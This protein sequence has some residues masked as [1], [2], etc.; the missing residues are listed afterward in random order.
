M[1]RSLST[2]SRRRTAPRSATCRRSCWPTAKNSSAAGPRPRRRR[3]PAEINDSSEEFSH[4]K[5]DDVPGNAVTGFVT[6]S[7]VVSAQAPARSAPPSQPASSKPADLAGDWA[8]DGR[9]GGI[10][11]SL[12]ISDIRGQ[13]RGNEDDIPYQP[14]AREKTLAERTSTGPDPQFGNTTDPQVLYCE[15]PGVPHIYLWPIKTKFIQTPEAV[16]IL[17]ELG[18]Y[19]RMV[20]LNSKHPG[21]S[22]PT[23][24]GRLNRLVR[25]RRHAGR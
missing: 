25:E 4:A 9:R 18:P 20:R 14:W 16:Y 2:S 17:H 15:P 19:Y 13:K 10:G 23:V 22:G 24:V 11:Q 5:S 6:F 1:T 8:P 3:L 7:L 12:S 21:R